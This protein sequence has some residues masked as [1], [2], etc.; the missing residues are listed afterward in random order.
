MLRLAHGWIGPD[1]IAAALIRRADVVVDHVSAVFADKLVLRE[2][3]R[4]FALPQD[5]MLVLDDHATLHLV[6]LGGWFLARPRQTL[7][8]WPAGTAT[9]TVG[10]GRGWFRPLT[11]VSADDTVTLAAPYAE[12]RQKGALALI[13]RLTAL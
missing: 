8:R 12:P 11:I 10:E 4:D 3:R 9:A 5:M 13:E 2:V 6:G 1:V 7:R